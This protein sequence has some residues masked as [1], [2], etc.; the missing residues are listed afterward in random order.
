MAHVSGVDLLRWP[1][2]CATGPTRNLREDPVTVSKELAVAIIPIRRGSS[3]ATLTIAGRSVL[4]G[5]IR[6]L[7]AV[8]SIGSIALALENIDQAA[9]LAAIERPETLGLRVTETMASRWLAMDAALELLD[10]SPIVVV[11]EPDRPLVSAD[12][13]A[14]LLSRSDEFEAAVTAVPV[15]D[16]IKRVRGQQIVD[17][18]PRETLHIS[19]TPWVFRREV[20]AAAVQQAIAD[21]WDV[22]DELQL[23]RKAEIRV[24]LAEGY[25][26]NLPIASAADARYAEIT[27]RQRGTAPGASLAIT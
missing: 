5:T 15:Q 14:M 1:T 27:T 23:A 21:R 8:P 20:L 18:V 13:L 3:S 9:C 12:G 22:R 10:G 17:T 6:A 4:D 25:R 7:R 19:Q 11:H 26:F 2:T 16:T 24:Q